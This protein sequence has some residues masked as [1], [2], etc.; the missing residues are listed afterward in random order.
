MRAAVTQRTPRPRAVEFPCIGNVAP[1]KPHSLVYTA[2]AASADS[3]N[4]FQGVS[5]TNMV[6]GEERAHFPGPRR[7]TN[8]PIFVARPGAEAEDDGWLLVLVNDGEAARTGLYVYDAKE[9]EPVA[10]AWL[11]G[12]IPYGL[13]GTWADGEV[14]GA[15]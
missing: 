11:N 8:E 9:M 15:V 14:F 1:R 6:T 10:I 4:P 12:V 7:F 2:C 3:N 5:R 13:H